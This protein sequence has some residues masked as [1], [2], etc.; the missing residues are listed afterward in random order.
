MARPK[1]S[2]PTYRLHKASGQA[3]CYVGRERHYLGKFGSAESKQRFAELVTCHHSAST[4]ADAKATPRPHLTLVAELLLRFVT[5]ELPRY[6]AAEQR[7]FD[8]VIRIV[9]HLFGTTPAAE[10]G[11]LRLRAVRQSMIDGAPG[12]S[13][14]PLSDGTAAPDRKPWSLSFTNKQ[15]KRL[16][17]IFRFGVSWEMVPQSVS[18]SLASVKALTAGESSA[19][20]SIPRTAVPEASLQAVR[21]LLIE[22]HR[23]IFDLL[24]LTGGRPG[25]IVGLTTGMIDRTGDVWK[26]E[27]VRHKTRHLGKRRVLFFNAT[28]QKILQRYLRADPE[29]RLFETAR[30][31]FGDAVRLA[32]RKANVPRFV[33]HQLR[34]TTAT[35]L[36]DEIGVEAAQRLLGHSQVAMTHHYSRM[37][38]R[39]ATQAVQRLG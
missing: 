3:C 16:R 21:G 23:D 8:G 30:D 37:A 10:F 13:L 26:A 20:E 24:L 14:P 1:L 36:V 34:H 19:R 39:L 27:L 2:V 6:G 25:E 15:I 33:P 29:A 7:C 9:R 17:S 28:A 35:R 18:D 38:D 22:R 12:A 32:C 4:L 11:P 31:S 5:D